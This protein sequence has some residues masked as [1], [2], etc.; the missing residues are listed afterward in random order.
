M[1]KNELTELTEFAE[2][3]E[4]KENKFSFNFT[5]NKSYIYTAVFY[6][7]G[8]IIGSVL[9]KNSSSETL[10]SLITSKNGEFLQLFIN[11]FCLYFSIFLVTVFLGFCLIGFPI[12][13]TVP[14]ICGLVIG[15]KISYYYIN[16]S[17]K[18]IGYCLIMI[19]P[20]AAILLSVVAFTIK[21]SSDM[22]KS[23]FNLSVKKNDEIE[24]ENGFDYRSN[25]KKYL[26]FGVVIVLTALFDAGMTCIFSTVITI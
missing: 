16:H 20:T 24:S 6:L 18:G 22:S 25:I 4:I 2:L 15:M 19:I 7:C 21:T 14:I 10:N 1:I 26:I 12:I 23:L 13:N 3:A 8:L 17:A 11:N 9:Y 5:E